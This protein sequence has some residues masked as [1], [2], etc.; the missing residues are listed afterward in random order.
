M[1]TLP[2]ENISPDRSVCEPYRE[3]IYRLTGLY[4]NPIARK[5]ISWQFCIWTLSR[6]N[7]SHDRS[8]CEPYREK[9]YRLTGLYVNPIARKIYLLTGLYVNPIARKYISWQVCMWTLSRENMSPERSECEPYREKIYRLTGLNV[10]PIARKYIAWQVWKYIAWQVG[11][12]TL[13]RESISFD[14]Q[15]TRSACIS[16]IWSESTLSWRNFGS[17]WL[18]TERSSGS[19]R[20]A[21]V[22]VDL[23]L[24]WVHM[25]CCYSFI[26]FYL[27]ISFFL[28]V[29]ILVQLRTA[30]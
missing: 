10:N 20:T 25:S 28:L 11:M 22:H 7:I 15:I 3:K 18:S 27:F 21:H 13:S 1:W 30:F 2:R 12:W 29:Y 4:V 26:L 5:Y 23:S 8:A 9:I 19:D 6:E 17:L 16:T 14:R 24:R